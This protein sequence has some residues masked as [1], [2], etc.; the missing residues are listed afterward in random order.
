MT[1]KWFEDKND[2]YRYRKEKKEE[3]E[4]I[5]TEKSEETSFFKKA[6]TSKNVEE[7]RPGLFVKAI[8]KNPDKIEYRQV[9]PLVWNGKW[10]L[11]NQISWRNVFMIVLITGLF[12]TGIKYVNFYEEVN[13]NPEEFCSNVSILNI[14]EVM[15]EDSSPLPGNPGE[16]EW[17]IP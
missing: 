12:F 8:P 6:F 11:K 2:N 16:V 10:R 14:G 5:P 9:Q 17:H 3:E 1:K 4:I 13:S 7:V 15:Y